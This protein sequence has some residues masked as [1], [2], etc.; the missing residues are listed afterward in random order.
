MRA[1]FL[2]EQFEDLEKQAHAA[3][4]GMWVFLSSELL[5]FAGLFTL[6][7]AYRTMYPAAF[8]ECVARNDVA[9]GTTNTAVLL[10]SSLVVALG[11]HEVRRGRSRRAAWLLLSAIA[12]GLVFLSLK[13]LEYRGHFHEGIFP[14]VGFRPAD[15]LPRGAVTFFSLYYLSTGL[16]AIHVVAGMGLLAWIAAGCFRRAYSSENDVR[17]ELVALYWHLVDVVWIFLWPMFYLMR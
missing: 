1:P 7:A 8:A 12:C 15:P 14:G 13:G 3:R 6:Y 2:H 9:I 10:T 16:H 11:L 5:L 17:V 4:L